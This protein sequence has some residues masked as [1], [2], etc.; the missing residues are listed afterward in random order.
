MKLRQGGFHSAYSV[1]VKSKAL[2]YV[3]ALNPSTVCFFFFWRWPGNEN[4]V[5]THP[6]TAESDTGD[7][8]NG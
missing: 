5:S 8:G 7:H 2:P 3:L 6:G 4:K 1:G